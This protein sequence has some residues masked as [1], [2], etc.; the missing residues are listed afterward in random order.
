[1][2]NEQAAHAPIF[3]DL[4]SAACHTG[5]NVRWLRRYWTR[6]LR[7]GVQIYRLPTPTDPD[8]GKIM[9]GT[10]SLVEW[11]EKR[12]IKELTP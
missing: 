10:A 9:F 6:L 5:L 8:K 7:E 1:M 3:L 11:L 4:K 2:Q 12:R